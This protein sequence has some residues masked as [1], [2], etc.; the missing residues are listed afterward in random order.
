MLCSPPP[1]GRPAMFDERKGL[2]LPVWLSGVG[3][4]LVVSDVL[5]IVIVIINLW[6]V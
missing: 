6:L 5:V 4:T 1:F 3:S 2:V